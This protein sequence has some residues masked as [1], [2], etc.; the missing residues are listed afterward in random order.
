MSNTTP[1][2]IYVDNDYC[3]GDNQMWYYVGAEADYCYIRIDVHEAA[4]AAEREA[5]AQIAQRLSDE[6]LLLMDGK[7]AGDPIYHYH[8][9]ASDAG[10]I[11]ADAI[12]ARDTGNSDMIDSDEE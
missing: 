11:I 3:D 7:Y 6:H 2:R 4:L 12:T 5:C 10:E 9:G 8:D 1:E